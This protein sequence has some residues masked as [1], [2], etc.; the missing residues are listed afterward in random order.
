MSCDDRHPWLTPEAADAMQRAAEVALAHGLDAATAARDM[1]WALH[2]SLPA[3]AISEAA[4]AVISGA[5][6]G[7][8]GVPPGL[9]GCLETP[10]R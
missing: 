3:L 2:P 10:S 1:A 9:R 4:E 5:R 6:L 7:A 8:G